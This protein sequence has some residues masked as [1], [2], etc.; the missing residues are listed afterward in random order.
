MEPFTGMP[1]H[2]LSMPRT[3]RTA[4][5]PNTQHAAFEALLAGFSREKAD[6]WLR[7]VFG[8]YDASQRHELPADG[9]SNEREHFANATLMGY[10]KNLPKEARSETNA[11][12]VVAAVH[13]K[14]SLERR[15]SR[16]VQFNYARKII[17]KEVESPAS[18]IHGLPTQGLF[19]FHDDFGHFRLSLVTGDIN[20]NRFDFNSVRRQSFLVE[21]G[22]KNNTIRRR[23]LHDIKSLADVKAVFSVE[24]L[25]KEFYEALFNWF[26]WATEED[27]SV[28]FPNDLSTPTDDRNHLEEAIIR[29][30]TRL[31]FIWF[32]KQKGIVPDDLFD[33]AKVKKHVTDFDPTSQEQDNYYRVILQNLFFATLNCREDKRKCKR[34]YRGMSN[35]RGI[36]TCYRYVAEMK[37]K[38]AFLQLMGRIPFLNCALFDCL[39]KIEREQDGGRKL[40][41]DGFSD[42]RERQAHIHNAF[43]F[44]ERKGLL[45]LFQQYEF[46]VDEN[47]LTDSDV[48]LDPE[49]LGKVFENLLGSYNPETKETARKATGAF[50]TPREIVN[51]MVRESLKCH[52]K[53][54][55]PFADDE[56]LA[57]LFDTNRA[58]QKTGFTPDERKALLEA[59]YSCKILDPACG[60][61]AFPMGILNTM[62]F[63][64]SR[65]DSD[66]VM[67]RQK[68]LQRYQQDK[69][70]TIQGAS[71]KEMEERAQMLEKQL[72]EGQLYP[73]YARK[74]FLIENCIYGIDIQPI[75]T[76]ISKLRF[77]ISL[78][79]DQLRSSYNPEAPSYGLLSLPNLESKFVCADTLKSL[80]KLAGSSLAMAT[81]NVQELKAQLNSYRHEVFLARTFDTKEKY[82]RLELE[83]RDRIRE[84][85]QTT[86]STPNTDL[87]EGCRETIA[88]LKEELQKYLE[89]KIELQQVTEQHDLFEAREEVL[90]EV[91]VN[92]KPRKR[93]LDEIGRAER[94][95]ATEE[96]KVRQ[97]GTT[98]LDMLALA[99]S[100]WDPY[101][102][103]ACS[104]FFDADWMF[105]VRDGFDII[106]GNPPY[107]QLQKNH[108]AYGDKYKECGYETYDRGGDMYMLFAE[109][110]N[111]LVCSEGAVCLIIPNKWMLLE[112]GAKMRS[113]LQCL[114]IHQLLNFGDVQFFDNAT[115]YICI[116]LFTKGTAGDTCAAL[117]VNRKTFS[118]SFDKTTSEE[119]AIV[120][121]RNFTTN[122]WHI[123][124]EI[125]DSI[126]RKASSKSSE[127]SKTSYEIN[128][129]I[130]TGY[131]DAFFI[132]EVTFQKICSS[133]K[134]SSDLIRPLLR[135]RDIDAY[136]S[137]K[138]PKYLIGTFP[139]LNI[140]I[141][142]YPGIKRHLLNYGKK[143]L[144]QS[145]KKYHTP[146]GHVISSRKRTSFS[147]FETQDSISYWQDFITP[148]IIYPQ[149]TTRFPFTYDDEGIYS[150]NSTFI[151][152]GTAAD[153]LLLL[154]GVLNSRIAKLW[155]WHHCPEL[156]G[157]AR[158][159]GK[160]FLDTF[161]VPVLSSHERKPI[162]KEVKSILKKKKAN[163]SADTTA[164]QERI[165][166]IL[167]VFYDFTVEEKDALTSFENLINKMAD[168]ADG[169]QTCLASPETSSTSSLTRDSQ[170]DIDNEYLD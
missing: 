148:K 96:A 164:E 3:P 7:H 133:D 42:R 103:N 23:F 8:S 26:V 88:K 163:L 117:S 16:T 119:I 166:D 152:T 131:N 99:V 165:E 51:Y 5:V 59:I 40:Y 68:L 118:G 79:C 30:I 144:E 116:L 47:S 65:L 28:T 76:Q 159:I 132:D 29:L 135:G 2:L 124:S 102:Q 64:L 73:D 53:R 10:V 18:G 11:P 62:V 136:V 147:W 24:A 145:G 82:K 45:P 121:T 92:E 21:E 75:A 120:S 169:S 158:E 168:N 106:I 58:D 115:T 100:K 80:P 110:A 1:C 71:Q 141:D 48:A 13:M 122:G 130:K 57:E 49:L 69:A 134:Q 113:Y 15:D 111:Q 36:A 112:A 146:E 160:V 93:I 60:S 14:H 107:V 140:K 156:N 97:A 9:T 151:I 129:G 12:M 22:G 52:L 55:C 31:M 35:E 167:A 170:Q 90:R 86:L 94:A 87:I 67:L 109:R 128:Y 125:Q 143:R 126:L 104:D 72:K 44:D 4:E 34:N 91:D 25:T 41:L 38:D 162:I 154:V 85:I 63:V 27:K 101:D 78:L 84:S 98:E 89:P 61:G 114:K 81:A 142:E 66:N 56:R 150:S 77:F 153:D 43:F 37:D 54:M 70:V 139:A 157:G 105:N 74:L 46:T 83:T 20:N 19:F 6:T 50:Y 123:I 17:K 95:I 137:E 39:D 127:L 161:P 155:I 138:K 32:I 33:A 149:I 108:G